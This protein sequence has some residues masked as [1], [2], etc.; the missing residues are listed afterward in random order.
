MKISESINPFKTLRIVLMI[1][2]FLLAATSLV[3]LLLL[4]TAVTPIQVAMHFSLG[5][6]MGVQAIEMVKMKKEK[7]VTLF[8]IASLLN[9]F[10]AAYILWLY[11]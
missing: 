6:F 9:M 2:T 1:V 5:L 4:K 11:L 8:T 10:G 7:Y 3:Y